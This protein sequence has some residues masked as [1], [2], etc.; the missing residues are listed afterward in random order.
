MSVNSGAV[1]QAGTIVANI[2]KQITG[3]S[4]PAPLDLSSYI[5]VATTTAALGMDKVYNAL[6]EMWGQTLIAVRPYSGP[7]LD[8]DFPTTAWG[9]VDRK[10]SF[11]SRLPSDDQGWE[12]PVTYDSTQ[13]VPTGDGGSV[14]PYTISKD[15]PVQTCYNGRDVYQTHRTRFLEQLETAFFNPEELVRYNAGALQE[16]SNDREQWAEGMRRGLLINA[17]AALSLQTGRVIHL[18]TEYNTATGLSLTATTVKQPANYAPF[19]RWVY[20]RL[21]ELKDLFAARNTMFTTQ[22]STFPTG[23]GVLRHTDAENMRLKLSASALHHMKASVL[24]TTYNPEMLNLDD[25][26]GLAYWQSPDAPDSVQAKP[27]YNGAD[28]SVTVASQSVTVENIFGVMYD[29]D[30][31]GCARIRA[32]MYTTPLNAAGRYYNDWYNESYKTRFDMTEKGIL[33]LLD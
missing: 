25:A 15:K 20:G 27:V 19:M 23:Y 7:L 14:D 2:Y 5:S 32:D 8:L 29:R 31:V 18:L 16:F 21:G 13:T 12:Y 24:S 30:M 22:F 33:L 17:I 4:V 10:I 3:L 6:S 28:G 1:Q 26:E 11:L 9:N